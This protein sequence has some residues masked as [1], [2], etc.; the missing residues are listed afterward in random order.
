MRIRT[1]IIINRVFPVRHLH[2]LIITILP[3]IPVKPDF[4]PSHAASE[5]NRMG[6]EKSGHNPC[7]IFPETSDNRLIEPEG[8]R[9]FIYRSVLDRLLQ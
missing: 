4:D 7:S 6:T 2:L 9:V 3:N 1:L 8:S 5:R